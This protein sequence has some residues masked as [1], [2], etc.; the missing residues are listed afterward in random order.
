[1]QKMNSERVKNITFGAILSAIVFFGVILRTMAWLKGYPLFYDEAS[2]LYNIN[3]KSTAELFLPLYEGQC[4]PPL[5]LICSK[6]IYKIFGANEVVLRFLPWLFSVLSLAIFC[7]VSTKVLK[8]KICILT[9]NALFAT[10]EFIILYTMFFKHYTCDAFFTVLIILLAFSIKDRELK[11]GELVALSVFGIISILFSYTS[12]FIIV[13]SFLVLLVYKISKNISLSEKKPIKTEIIKSI[14][15]IIPLLIFCI[16]YFAI[17]CIYAIKSEYLQHFWG[18]LFGTMFPSDLN[19][20]KNF[21]T[22]FASSTAWEISTLLFFVASI[23]VTIKKDKFFFGI[24]FLPFIFGATAGLLHLY[25]FFAERVSIYLIPL[26]ILGIIKPIDYIEFKG[27]ILTTTVITICCLSLFNYGKIYKYFNENRDI[28]TLEVIKHNYEKRYLTE[29]S[30]FVKEFIEFLRHSDYAPDNYI[31]CKFANHRLLELYDK[32]ENINREKVC[33]FPNDLDEVPTG[34]TI[35][36][37]IS[38]K[39]DNI[40][41]ETSE[42]LEKHGKV[43]YEIPSFGYKFLKVKKIR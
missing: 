20:A 18:V 43:S 23:F 3:E 8:N 37:C 4:C 17:N 15:F 34:S 26:F 29:K 22:F 16:F 38:E 39:Y 40:Y 21:L 12:F 41:P 7:K 36:F 25:P 11:K 35:F 31:F 32:K 42:W 1:M 5:F 19:Q 6:F 27:K 13:S 2:L 28:T 9:A 30:A 14:Y 10:S 33:Y 24:I